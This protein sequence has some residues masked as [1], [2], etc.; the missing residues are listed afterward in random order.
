MREHRWTE[1]LFVGCLVALGVFV[2]LPAGGPVQ[3]SENGPTKQAERLAGMQDKG[4]KA[5]L[6]IFPV[7]LWD[8]KEAK[9][10]GGLGGDIA[11]VIGL[12]LE[13]S[14]MENLETADVPFLLPRDVEFDKAAERFGE[15]VRAHPIKTDYALYAE[16]LGRTSPP[17]FEEVRGVFVE[18]SGEV[19]WVE[20]QT[21][22]SAEFKHIQPDC[23]MDCCVLLT[24]RLGAQ[25]GLPEAK[26]G[27]G[28]GKL[29]KLWAGKSGT[30]EHAETAGMEERLALMKKVSPAAKVA[31]FPIQTWETEASK[32]SA[33]QLA[34]MLREQKL[35]NAEVVET[36]LHIDL[37][38]TS[39]EQKAL[40]DLA[41][42]FREQVKNHRPDTDYVLFAEYGLSPRD[43]R[44]MAVHFVVCD[45]A[46]EWVI[47]DF[48][49]D[50]HGDF[51]SVAPKTLEDCNKLVA[52]RL[53]GYLH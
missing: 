26:E 43:G 45:R 39:N 49:N 8:T 37:Q 22:D 52:R 47:V 32:E 12:L 27:A 53:A 15:F 36:P 1:R 46:G 25:L 38:R 20:R 50:H 28:E 14:G 48:Q 34:S 4:V 7:V 23:P 10:V 17:R 16:F 21:P 33:A 19:V 3:A 24:E 13:Q 5:S 35:F 2:V 40:W 31:V 18:K 44:V 42:G 51:Q 30:P 29:A 41:R 6:T 11:N 9:D